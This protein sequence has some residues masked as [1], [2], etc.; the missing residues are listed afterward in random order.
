[1]GE[2]SERCNGCPFWDDVRGFCFFFQGG[3][4]WETNDKKDDTTPASD[5]PMID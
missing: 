4:L 3:C 2:R 1:M 5:S